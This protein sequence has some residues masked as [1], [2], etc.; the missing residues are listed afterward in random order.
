MT[1]H[2]A[3]TGGGP[4][5]EELRAV[6]QLLQLVDKTVKTLRL[7]PA[8]NPTAQRFLK[9][10]TDRFLDYLKDCGSLK[11]QVHQYALLCEGQPVYENTNRRESLALKLFLDGIAELVFHEGLE[12]GEL[13][14]FLEILIRDY[15][16]DTADDDLVT[17]LW[18]AS[19]THIAFA[20]AEEAGETPN[21]LLSS[22]ARVQPNLRRVLKEESEREA[23]TL[24]LSHP[25]FGVRGGLEVVQLTSAELQR[26]EAEIA[27]E[28]KA[29]TTGRLIEML[30]AILAIETDDEAFREVTETVGRL[31]AHTTE[32][33]DWSHS[34]LA[35]E[36]L[37]RLALRPDLSDVQRKCLAD[38]IDRAGSPDRIKAIGTVLKANK[39][40]AGAAL[41]SLL[42]LLNPN[43]L[44]PLCEL[45]AR[46]E[47]PDVRGIVADALVRLGKD[48]S[49]ILA[50]RLTDARWELVRDLVSVLG[51]IGAPQ[52]L[53]RF[54]AL[55]DHPQVAV[56]TAVLR[57]VEQWDSP[58][59][60]DL[61][62][63]LLYDPHPEIRI[64]ASRAL[65]NAYYRPAAEDFVKIIKSG[66][67][68]DKG[69]REK[70]VFFETLGAL[71]GDEVIP[72]L[73]RILARTRRFFL[74]SRRADE[75]G[76]GA[77]L[78]LKR[79]GT[80]DAVA[81]LEDGRRRRNKVIRE[82]CSQALAEVRGGVGTG[83]PR[84]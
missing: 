6:T 72:L 65:A 50:P 74:R 23:S 64:A 59:A 31:L 60:R 25:K 43:A 33:G 29:H 15:D 28:A 24:N 62:V 71:G 32:T 26:L 46:L 20:V 73:D 76:V 57:A 21:I 47:S 44:L 66:A 54:R 4:E 16:P 27:V 39:E 36:T 22:L 63:N 55:V 34:V 81:V 79:I 5:Q 38:A 48:S 52:A 56:R 40:R 2:G 10:L 11:L 45:L 17:L 49:D 19:L 3:E 51:R 67:C 61:L 7:Y 78:A 69:L 70:R 41:S 82:A 13:A 1:I 83:N 8:S 42:P 58:K 30:A 53:D 68:A 37:R 80:P 18:E 9:E 35:L 12:A 14:R 75:M 77:V 84:R